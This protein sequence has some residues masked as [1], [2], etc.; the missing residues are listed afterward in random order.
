MNIK[1]LPVCYCWLSEEPRMKHIISCAPVHDIAIWSCSDGVQ[2]LTKPQQDILISK[3]IP[4]KIIGQVR[5]NS[6]GLPRIPYLHSVRVLQPSP[7]LLGMSVFPATFGPPP[8]HVRRTFLVHQAP[9]A[10]WY[11][12]VNQS[13]LRYGYVQSV[14]AL[15]NQK[16]RN[17]RGSEQFCARK[18]HKKYMNTTLMCYFSTI[19]RRWQ[20]IFIIISNCSSTREDG[21]Q[22]QVITAAQVVTGFRFLRVLYLLFLIH[23]T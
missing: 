10:A 18:N 20:R 12:H 4:T 5:Q 19:S 1:K 14:R 21:I 16:I 23:V 17:R 11:E 9:F 15:V 8:C 2:T 6:F 13:C 3:D 22:Q 7:L